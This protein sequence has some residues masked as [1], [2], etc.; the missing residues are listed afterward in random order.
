MLKIESEFTPKGD[1]PKAIADLVS[2]LEDGYRFQT[3]LGATGTGKSVAWNEPV[4][5]HLGADQY[6]RG[7]IGQLLDQALG[8]E[9]GEEHLELPPPGSWRVLAWNAE[10]GATD[11]QPI[12]ALSRHMTPETMY[13]LETNC[14]RSV[15]VTGD[16]SVWVLRSGQLHLLPGD[17]VQP[18]DAMPVPRS[19][20]EPAQPLKHLNLLE[21][22]GNQASTLSV[23]VRGGFERAGFSQTIDEHYANPYAKR[24]AM[25]TNIRGHGVNLQTATALLEREIM[26][27]E[28]LQIRGKKYSINAKLELNNTLGFVFGQYIAEGHA[29]DRYALISVRDPE[30]QHE[31]EQS[32]HDLEIPFF[33]RQDGDFVIGARVWRDVMHALMG[34]LAGSKRLPNFWPALSNTVLASVLRGYFEG[35]GGL[36][37]GAVT[38]VTQ[39]AEL[40]NDLNEACLR[41]GIW[42]RTRTVRKRKPSGE[43][44]TYQKITIS[45]RNNLEHYRA[46]Q[47][48]R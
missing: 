24:Y 32:L 44:G 48:E 21:V 41:F 6:F 37:G 1:Q 20:P 2:G 47:H 26:P 9:Q 36:E 39:S 10:N 27:L 34:G 17:Q 15:T 18:G 14:G 28:E 40:A 42:A 19:I 29:A 35:D 30:V 31:L 45:G 22:L 23:D 12:T 38:A 33:R 8:L 16:H 7:P 4:T 3:L 13:K 5:V 11:W 25:R 46:W 43:I